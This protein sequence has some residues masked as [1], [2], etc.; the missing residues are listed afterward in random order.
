MDWFRMKILVMKHFLLYKLVYS[1]DYWDLEPP[2]SHFSSAFAN[3]AQNFNV[4]SDC[5]FM[6]RNSIEFHSATFQLADM[7]ISPHIISLHFL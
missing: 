1:I 2:A 5:N 3:Q 4:G 7:Q 6:G